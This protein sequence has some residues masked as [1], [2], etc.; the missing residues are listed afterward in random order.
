MKN[1]KNLCVIPARG[2]SKRFPNK[3]I[4]LL[5]GKPLVV[6][7]IDAAIDSGIFDKIIFTSDSDIILE[8]VSEY[9]GEFPNLSIEKRP[10]AL[11]T[12][13]SKVIDTVCFYSDLNPEFEKIWLLLP[14]CPL[15]EKSDILAVNEMMDR[16]ID[17]VVSI[18]E[19]E[20]PPT[21]GLNFDHPGTGKITSWDNSDPW[22]NGNTRGQDH[23]TVFRPNGA[24]YCSWMDKFRNNKNFYK[25]TARG[26]FMPRSKSIDID[27]KFDF[28]LAQ[29]SSKI[30][31]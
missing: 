19:M 7:T 3:N 20:F 28:E 29:I 26:Y 25:G 6:H 14:T 5:N 30:I 23:P 27:T 13:T 17:S 10:D 16:E 2:G 11:A 31:W 8:I 4:S 1:M 22:I 24:V 15:R 12:D 21:L 18:T 9:R